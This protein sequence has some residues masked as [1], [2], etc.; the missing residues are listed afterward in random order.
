MSPLTE[1]LDLLKT[2]GVRVFREG[3][4]HIE[5]GP[6]EQPADELKPPQVREAC[7]CGHA[8][9]EHTNGLCM[10]CDPGKCV[11]KAEAS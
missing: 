5:F 3:D 1:L 7:S 2:K 8:V 6:P 11:E 4:L 9:W 10:H